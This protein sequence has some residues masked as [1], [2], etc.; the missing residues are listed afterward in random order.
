MWGV[1]MPEMLRWLWR[2]YP[3]SDDP[4]NDE[5]RKVYEPGAAPNFMPDFKGDIVPIKARGF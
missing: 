2:D 3:R 1:M 5:N 4:A